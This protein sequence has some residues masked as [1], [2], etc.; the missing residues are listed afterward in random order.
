MNNVSTVKTCSN[1]NKI[2]IL[3]TRC[4]A[5]IVCTHQC[6]SFIFL[7]VFCRLYGFTAL[8]GSSIGPSLWN[9]LPPAVCFKILSGNLSSSFSHLKSSSLGVK[10][11][12]SAS[13]RL[14]LR[15]A[16][17]NLQIQNNYF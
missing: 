4:V 7:S 13:E 16:F 8:L 15:E 14:M 2:S 5:L 9:Q 12:R 11:T 10:R 1:R 6:V 17:I 3:H